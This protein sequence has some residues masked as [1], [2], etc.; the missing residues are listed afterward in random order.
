MSFKNPEYTSNI[1]VRKFNKYFL[2]I[3][4]EPII[5]TK[6]TNEKYSKK[7]VKCNKKYKILTNNKCEKCMQLVDK[8]VDNTNLFI[9]SKMIKAVKITKF[10]FDRSRNREI[11]PNVDNQEGYEVEYSDGYK[12]WSPK[13]VFEK[14]YFQ[15]SNE[16]YLTD[17]DILNF[18]SKVETYKL[19]EK[20]TAVTITLRNGFELTTT[21][22]CVVPELYDHE[23]GCQIA[24]MKTKDKIWELLGFLMQTSK[25]GLTKS[26]MEGER[27]A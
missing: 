11:G 15:I 17:S 9:G 24:T 7:C 12:S 26:K 1:V 23:V 20:T 21:S 5:I 22:S 13:E 8:E 19:G 25:Y 18:I 3:K 16:N 6:K 14:S 10:D 4:R 27:N 2:D